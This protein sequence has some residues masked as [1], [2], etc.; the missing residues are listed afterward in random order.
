MGDN[1][2]VIISDPLLNEFGSC[3]PAILIAQELVSRNYDVKIITLNITRRL[4]KILENQGITVK[5]LQSRKSI[6]PYSL[7]WFKS[8]LMEALFSMNSRKVKDVEGLKLNFSNVI[9]LPS[10]FWY[11]QGPPSITLDN[12]KSSFS[13]PYKFVYHLG[14]PF[15]RFVDMRNSKK[16]YALSGKVISNSRYLQEIYERFGIRVYKV[17]Y[18][19]IDCSKFKPLSSN[20]VSDY[21][22]TYFGKETDLCV[23]KRLADMGVKIKVFGSKLKT[24]HVIKKHPNIDSL[25]VISEQTLVELY[26]NA[27]IT[28]YPFLD[29][30][31][32]Y[33]PIESMACGTP[34]LTYNCQG[35][36]ETVIH[37]VSG[38]LTNSREE[39]IKSAIKIWREGYPQRMRREC[40]ERAMLFDKKTIA[41]EW[42]NN[43]KPNVAG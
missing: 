31:F 10:D 25:G 28:L 39:F 20:P 18:P 16:F 1:K 4:Q 5:A 13:L 42:T 17:I 37:G 26:S 43:I 22:I 35:P 23:I 12:I 15:F 3:R 29:E 24:P 41:E 40:R 14:R 38:W 21:V 30:P 19:P 6:L 33:V 2:I 11:A 34:V 32:G 7:M 27:L 8:W 36:K 9:C